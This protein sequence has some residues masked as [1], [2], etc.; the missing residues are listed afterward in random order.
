MKNSTDNHFREML[1]DAAWTTWLFM[2]ALSLIT[3]GVHILV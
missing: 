3:L 1:I 2:I